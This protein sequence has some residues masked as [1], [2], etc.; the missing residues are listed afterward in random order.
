MV[1][2]INSEKLGCFLVTEDALP[3]AGQPLDA[4]HFGVGQYV[5]ATGKTI[6]WGF[7]VIFFN[8]Q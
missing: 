1:K 8:L 3:S 6:D 5:I 7:Q 4:R 2:K